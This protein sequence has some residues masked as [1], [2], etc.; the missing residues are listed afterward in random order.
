MIYGLIKLKN[1]ITLKG[2]RIY[3]YEK[4]INYFFA[5]AFGFSA[6]ASSVLAFT[7]STT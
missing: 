1:P 6:L 3:I 2:N 7:S 4:V 5:L